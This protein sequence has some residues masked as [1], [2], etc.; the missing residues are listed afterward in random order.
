M[1]CSLYLV[2]CILYLQGNDLE[3]KTEDQPI[4]DSMKQ[5]TN[6][7]FLVSCILYLQ[8]NDL[9][10]KTEDQPIPDSMKQRSHAVFRITEVDNDTK[11]KIL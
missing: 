10:I 9:E 1:Q 11:A 6:S 8:G 7:V 3:I 2:S 4:P 5:R